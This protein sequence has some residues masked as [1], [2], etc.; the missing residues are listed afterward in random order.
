MC[1]YCI[2]ISVCE[3]SQVHENRVNET[4]CSDSNLAN[5]KQYT[6]DEII[7]MAETNDI[8]EIKIVSR[9]R[10]IEIGSSSDCKNGSSKFFDKL[11]YIDDEVFE[12]IKDFKSG[13]LPYA[14]NGQITVVYID[15]IAQE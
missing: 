9:N 12:T 10:V 11:Y 6:I 3:L 8:I 5:S 2:Y 14:I 4:I 1:I 15:G 7:L 13:L